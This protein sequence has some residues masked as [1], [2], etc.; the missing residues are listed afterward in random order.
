MTSVIDD[1]YDVYGTVE[2]LENFTSAVERWDISAI[3]QLPEY[4]KCCYEA[5]LDVY[6]EN[7]NDFA[8]EGK[9][10]R[11]DYAKEAMK[12]I[13]RNYFWEAKWLMDDMVSHK[14]E[15]KRGHVASS[16]ECFMN[17]HGATE[18]ETCKHK[19]KAP[20]KATNTQSAQPKLRRRKQHKTHEAGQNK[21]E[22]QQPQ[23]CVEAQQ[24]ST[25]AQPKLKIS[26][27]PTK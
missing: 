4:M 21:T 1:I 27:P 11:L 9:L 18:E 6:S 17:Q 5:L 3:D 7:E 2:E 14:F 12:D 24:N 8:C 26:A 25:G 23:N 22:K 19:T 16:V 15:Q 13:V 20:T 10:Y